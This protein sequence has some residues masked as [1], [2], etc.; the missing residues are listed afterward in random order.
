MLCIFAS[1][2]IRNVLHRYI[3]LNLYI[4][5]CKLNNLIVPDYLCKLTYEDLKND[6][7]HKKLKIE[8]KFYV[9]NN[10]E[11]GKNIYF[12]IKEIN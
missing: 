5:F 8:R 12:L 3:V 10:K 7:C 2:Q 4:W 6:N 1:T 9:Q 11:N